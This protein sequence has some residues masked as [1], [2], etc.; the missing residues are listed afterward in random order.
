MK[1]SNLNTSAR[2]ASGWKRRLAWAA[3][4]VVNVAMVYGAL[5]ALH[6]MRE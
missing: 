5:W 4:G 2:H 3:L 6:W 1:A